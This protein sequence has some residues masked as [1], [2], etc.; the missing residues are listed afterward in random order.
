MIDQLIPVLQEAA[1]GILSI[2]KDEDR[3]NVEIKSDNSPLTAADK[4]SNEIICSALA[5]FYPRIPVIS[6]EKKILSYSERSKYKDYFLIDPLDGT[7]EF[8]KRNGEFTVN[9]GYMEGSSAKGGFIIQPVTGEIYV[10]EKGVGVWKIGKDGVRVP[11]A[12]KPFQLMEK[13]LRV[14]ASRSHRDPAT[15]QI[16]SLL[17]EPEIVSAG[18]SL[19]F[20]RL[21]EGEAQF[22]PRLA[23]TMEWDTAA[24]QCILEE[25]G[26]SI[27]K[28]S[29]LLPLEYNKEDLLNPHFIAVGKLLDPETLHHLVK[30]VKTK[31]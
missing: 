6:E 22:Y 9:I 23:P 1:K 26:G 30:T 25:A 2:Y 13:G 4:L 11:I 7:K 8:I 21:T 17:N 15:N 12:S 24:A 19:K 14:L 29:D 3:F 27:V 16:I 18:S 5:D 31:K 28:Y 20:L 10:A